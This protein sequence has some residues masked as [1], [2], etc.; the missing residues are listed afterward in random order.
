VDAAA[1]LLLGGQLEETISTRSESNKIHREISELMRD[2]L[3]AIEKYFRERNDRL[4]GLIEY[5]DV[6]ESLILLVM[7][8]CAV[9]RLFCDLLCFKFI[10]CVLHV[11]AA[12]KAREYDVFLVQRHVALLSVNASRDS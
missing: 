9:V 10:S 1:D 3:K 11:L 6:I 2:N 4:S 5:I 7:E 8:Q 12:P